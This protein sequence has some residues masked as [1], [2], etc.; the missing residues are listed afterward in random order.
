[1]YAKKRIGMTVPGGKTVLF[2]RCS[3]KG[4][5]KKLRLSFLTPPDDVGIGKS[6]IWEKRLRSR[7]NADQDTGIFA[8]LSKTPSLSAAS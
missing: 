8:E 1:M 5:V 6:K 2:C 3:D 4:G 7:K